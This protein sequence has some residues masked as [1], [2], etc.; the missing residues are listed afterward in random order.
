MT[1]FDV[2][3]IGSGPAGAMAAYDLAEKGIS[4]VLVEKEKLPRYKTCGGGLVYRGRNLMPFD[5]TQVTERAF[6]EV[7][8]Y[9]ANKSHYK[10]RR[11]Q[12]IITMVM[13]DTFD[14]FITEQA[15]AKGVTILD[16]HKV[17]GLTFNNNLL[18][19][20]TSQATLTTKFVI[21]ADGALTPIAKMAGW[22]KDTRKLIPA[23]EYEVT[24][25]AE[26][27][28]RL[29]ESVR[30][31]MDAIPG[32]YAWCFPKKN[33]L[34]IGVA[35][36]KRTRLNLK[37]Y[38]AKYIQ[39]LGIEHVITEA[40]HGFQIPVS[41]RTDGFVKNG[42]FLTGDAAGFADPI[43]AEGISNSLYSGKLAAQA[44]I[45]SELNS[46]LAETIYNRLLEEHLLPEL[47]TAGMLG[48]FFY[49]HKTIRNV[50]LKKYGECFCEAMADIFMGD[51]RYPQD[52]LQKIQH[53]VKEFIF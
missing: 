14:E 23:L 45:D 46:E 48:D 4:T 20:H 49:N 18:T 11:G 22:Q 3:V 28:I 47:K 52:A 7:D 53:K 37:E 5:I 2:A 41:Y 31:D 1:H 40:Q 33:H 21:A 43:T 6:Y 10:T 17:N 34:S 32:G 15:K 35:S 51:K 24:V 50:L 39:L 44:I 36:T 29:S 42:V 26:E 30:F 9:F 8:I 16:Q 27:F 19:I 12:P 25:A 38:Y 13:R